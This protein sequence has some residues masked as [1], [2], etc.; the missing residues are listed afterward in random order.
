LALTARGQEAG[1]WPRVVA[2]WAA[3]P[4]EVR[5]AFDEPA[6]VSLL[7]SLRGAEIRGGES[8]VGGAE[9]A[10]RLGVADVRL[11]EMGR[12]LA[13]ATDPHPRPGSY[14]LVVAPGVGAHGPLPS[15]VPRIEYALNGVDVGFHDDWEAGQDETPA[16]WTTWWPALDWATV[17]ERLKGSAE[18]ERTRRE[19]T[20]AG[21]LVIRTRVIAPEGRLRF[22]LRSS[23][24]IESAQFAFEPAE[25]D[26][27]KSMEA[28]WVIEAENEPLD[29]DLRIR[30]SGVPFSLSSTLTLMGSATGSPVPASGFLLPWAPDA[31]VLAPATNDER[32]SLGGGDVAR[33]R[34]V[35]ESRE[36]NCAACH[37]FR[38]LGRGIGPDLSELSKRDEQWIYD[39]IAA[40]SVRIDPAFQPWTIVMVDGRIFAGLVRTEGFEHFRVV[41]ADATETRLARGEVQELRPSATSIMPVGLIGVLGDGRVRDLIAYLRS[42]R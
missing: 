17:D 41:G 26:A 30:H 1:E 3:S 11:L 34:V 31:P 7:E 29:L 36:A 37:Q 9:S 5:V 15:K 4:F 27:G 2:I 23:R 20:Q 18:H 13:V 40:P 24:P 22:A 33:G 10:F 21:L 32:P 8:A 6:R 35:F 39:Q 25:I 28:S 16:R 12:V 19:M 42:T 38:G 14:R